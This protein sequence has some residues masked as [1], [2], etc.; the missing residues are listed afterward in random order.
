MEQL[1][2]TLPVLPDDVRDTLRSLGH[3]V[4][5]FGENLA[6]IRD[7]LKQL[8]LELKHIR[9]QQQDG[10]AAS[11]ELD[12]SDDDGDEEE[13]EEEVTKYTRATA[14][15]L[16]ARAV[17]A[18][19]SLECSQRRLEQERQWRRAAGKRKKRTAGGGTGEPHDQEETDQDDPVVVELNELD[20]L[21]SRTFQTFR[22]FT[23]EGSQY[24]DARAI[25]S[26]CV[27]PCTSNR[28]GVVGTNSSNNRTLVVTASWNAAIK[29]WDTTPSTASGTSSTLN[30]GFRL[31]A[32]S[33]ERTQ[34]HTDRIMGLSAATA[35]NM[36][37]T[38]SLDGM[39]K[40]WQYNPQRPTDSSANDVEMTMATTTEQQDDIM[41]NMKHDTDCD[42]NTGHAIQLVAEL[43]G[44]AR[45]TC[46][47]AFYP[48]TDH[49]VATTSFDHT[50]RL[51]NVETSAELLLQDGHGAPVYGLSFHPDGSLL[52]TTDYL[53]VIHLWDLRTSKS[54][55]HWVGQHAKRVL[56]V[57][58]LPTGFQMASAGDDG[59][60]RIWDLR[61]P[62]RAS[63]Q[64][65][66]HSNLITQLCVDDDNEC[67]VSSSFDG[68]VKVWNSRNW[69]LLNMLQGHD[70]KVTGVGVVRSA[71]T[72]TT[73]TTTRGC[74]D[75]AVGIV[76]CGF[77]KTLK[78]W[79]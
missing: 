37:C 69:K 72:T 11:D 29:V 53:G 45:R 9:R 1:P 68:T 23:L 18:K 35:H 77:D 6:N 8:L 42:N 32:A 62:K 22:E 71:R 49:Y 12:N 5:L 75:A 13:E 47:S 44:H 39:A 30:S 56:Q 34:C 16:A 38:T 17:I 7:R 50:W 20:A 10:T 58:M 60:I 54:L 61:R 64:I 70:G 3:P 27:L 66:A 48:R 74:T 76:S 78:L 28:S 4:R 19:L 24:A 41:N 63:I 31:P 73:T 21:A 26:L 55:R 67:L 46:R 65:P 51:W 15:L 59:T 40:L 25:S 52:A 57:Q 14:E 33:A 43:K 36:F 79:C 2:T